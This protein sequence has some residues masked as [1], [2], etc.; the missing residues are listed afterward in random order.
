MAEAYRF[1]NDST[2]FLRFEKGLD[3]NITSNHL[4]IFMVAYLL[5]IILKSQPHICVSTH[6]WFVRR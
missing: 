2:G 3:N 4:F 6:G 5:I 1:K